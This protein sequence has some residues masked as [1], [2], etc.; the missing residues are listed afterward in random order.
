[1]LCG[2]VAHICMLCLGL[3]A[4]GRA[5]V[6][7]S[8]RAC[9]GVRAWICGCLGACALSVLQPPFSVRVSPC[10]WTCVCAA[11][12]PLICLYLC[13]SVTVFSVSVRACASQPVPI[14][15][16]VCAGVCASTV[17]APL[18]VPV[19]AFAR[20]VPQCFFG[21]DTLPPSAQ[22]NSK[23]PQAQSREQQESQGPP[24]TGLP[25]SSS[26][27]R[28]LSGVA[29]CAGNDQRRLPGQGKEETQLDGA[30]EL[31][32]DVLSWRQVGNC[33]GW[34]PG[35]CPEY[36]PLMWRAW[37]SSASPR[38]PACSPT[39]ELSLYRNTKQPT[40]NT[41]HPGDTQPCACPIGPQHQHTH[42]HTYLHSVWLCQQIR[43]LAHT[44]KAISAYMYSHTHIPLHSVWMSAHTHIYTT[45]ACGYVSTH[46]P[47]HSVWISASMYS[48]THTPLHSV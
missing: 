1:M 6:C 39:S 33:L 47:L 30:P 7:V 5:S 37:H 19:C 41:L 29:E 38:P 34:P 43:A 35:S 31:D 24:P 3:C 13:S 20:K 12:S 36:W 16:H 4:G 32:R 14:C 27:S 18:R 28:S 25:P 9:V 10:V 46:T 2:C 21:T 40:P 26:L 45:I 42:V 22:T 48:H 8:V 23:S 11:A 44:H 15:A 17:W